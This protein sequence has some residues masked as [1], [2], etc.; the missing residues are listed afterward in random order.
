[1]EEYQM[2]I[3]LLKNKWRK[4]KSSILIW[5][6]SQNKKWFIRLYYIK[7]FF[8]L[9]YTV[10]RYVSISDFHSLV[11]IAIETTSSAVVLKTCAITAAIQK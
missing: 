11:V 10:T 1:M 7:P 4:Q 3:F 2:N 5:K 8:T 9:A 6:Y